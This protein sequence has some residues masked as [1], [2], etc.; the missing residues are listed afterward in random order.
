[1]CYAI[2]V[3]YFNI[4]NIAY[5]KTHCFI[6]K[7]P[8]IKPDIMNLIEEK[9]GKNLEHTGSGEN[10][11]N[12]TPMAY[13]LR[14]RTDK[15]DLIKSKSLCKAK[16]TVNRTKQQSTDWEKIFANLISNRGLKYKIYEELKK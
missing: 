12:R 3:N 16:D 8:H 9:V 2:Q 11:L 15:W 7:D 4:F 1:L 5:S 13:A 10:F 6:F 14:S